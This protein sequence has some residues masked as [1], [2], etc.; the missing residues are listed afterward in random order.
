MD[1]QQVR[2]LQEA[3]EVA[4]VGATYAARAS[5]LIYRHLRKSLETD[6][7]INETIDELMKAS[8]S[9]CDAPQTNAPGALIPL[10]PVPLSRCSDPLLH[11]IEDAYKRMN[12][13]ERK[14]YLQHIRTRLEREPPNFH[15]IGYQDDE[16]RV[17]EGSF[18][19]LLTLAEENLELKLSDRG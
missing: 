18:Y 19:D 12:E 11:R 16:L 4:I 5:E 2:L 13:L 10:G 17:L 3:S 8:S 1:P 14:R 9:S 7:E 6:E 15:N